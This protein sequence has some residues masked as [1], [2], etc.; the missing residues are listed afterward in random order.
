MKTRGPTACYGEFYQ[1]DARDVVL[2]KTA[3]KSVAP[4]SSRSSKGLVTDFA[5]KKL[6]SE[7][8]PRIPYAEAMEK[9]GSDKPDLRFGMEL[10][11][12]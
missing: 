6:L 8:V 3:R 12:L 7:D 1:L 11:E 4:S 9:Y 10:V 5:G 2:S